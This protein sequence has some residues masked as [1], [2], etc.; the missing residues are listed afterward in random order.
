MSAVDDLL[1]R[2]DSVKQT[3][4]GRWLARCP[5]HP[6][7]H[8]SLAVRELE[9]GRVLVHDFAGCDTASIL[10]S[11]GLEFSS[12]F[13]VRSLGNT[14]RGERRP[15]NAID[16]LRCIGFEAM[17]CATAAANIAQGQILSDSDRERLVTAAARLQRAVE[18]AHA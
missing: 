13:P 6:D 9:D 7:K 18:V 15:F 10:S 12:L 5:A 8:P 3:G 14:V 4:S 2:L 1:A 17:V 16:I 11:V